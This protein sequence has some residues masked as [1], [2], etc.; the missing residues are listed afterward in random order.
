M[1]C[2]LEDIEEDEGP[3]LPSPRRSR[4]PGEVRH[5]AR[6]NK[7]TTCVK[8]YYSIG[9]RTSLRNNIMSEATPISISSD[10]TLS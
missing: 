10:Y 1:S 6:S 3:S 4:L 8:P 9:L 7:M 5:A 2:S